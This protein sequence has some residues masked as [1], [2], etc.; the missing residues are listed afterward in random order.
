MRQ[1]SVFFGAR[2]DASG[3]RAKLCRGQSCRFLCLC[4][5][6]IRCNNS[7]VLFYPNICFL[8]NKSPVWIFPRCL[9]FLRSVLENDLGP[10]GMCLNGAESR[11]H[12]WFPVS[13]L[14]R[15]QSDIIPH[16]VFR[17]SK[18]T[19]ALLRGTSSQAETVSSWS[20]SSGHPR[21]ACAQWSYH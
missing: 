16:G 10:S 14:C 19:V 12:I 1:L 4:H 9:P 7:I 20:L 5:S 18:F 21:P 13:S 3:R 17:L 6:D 11:S 15:L 8:H 2:Y